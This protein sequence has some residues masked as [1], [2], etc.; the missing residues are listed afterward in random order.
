MGWVIGCV[1]LCMA[2]ASPLRAAE[3]D[4]AKA[5]WSVHSPHN[6]ALNS[7]SNDAVLELLEKLESLDAADFKVYSFQFADLRHSGYLSLVISTCS[8]VCG[9]NIIDRTPAGF[10]LYDVDSSRNGNID[11]R[12]LE[13]SRNLELITDVDLTSYEGAGHCGAAWP[14]IYAWTGNGYGDVS[15]RYPQYYQ[16]RLAPL[17]KEIAAVTAAIEQARVAAANP[18]P[19]PQPTVIRNL[20][21]GAPPGGFAPDTLPPEARSAQEDS[22]RPAATS[23]FVQREVDPCIKAEAGKIERFLGSPNAGLTDAIEWAN[24]DDPS[25]REF[26]TDILLDI[27][28]PEAIVFLK[29]L[30]HDSN[31]TVAYSAKSGLA[32]VGRGPIVHKVEREDLADS[33]P[34]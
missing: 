22:P 21:F 3:P 10:E 19:M 6:L 33:P 8:R 16:Q 28:T 15:S 27:G 25:T 13:G 11:V 26:A 18:T 29:T 4:L 31:R 30:S 23:V 24:S 5:D 9:I 2:F 7:P 14:V 12:D 1:A 32:E 17:K 20:K 34:N